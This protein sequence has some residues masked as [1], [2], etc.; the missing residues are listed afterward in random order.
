M[1][2]ELSEEQEELV[3]LLRTVLDQ[4]S[5]GPA[6]RRAMASELGYDPELWRVLSEE[7]GAAALAIPEE[8]GGV[9]FTRLEQSLVLEGLG[10][11]LAPSPYL[12]SV[13]IA[14]EAVRSATDEAVKERLLPGIA[15]GSSIAALAWADPHGRWNPERVDAS[16]DGETRT[17]SGAIPLV[18][19]GAAADVLL[20]VA[21]TPNGPGLFEVRDPAAVQRTVTPALD[22]TLRFATLR[23][24]AVAVDPILTGDA[25]ALDRLRDRALVAVSAL[26][27]GAAERGLAMT[28]EYSKQRVQFGR[29]IGSFQALKHR[30]ADMHVRL[31]TARTASRA[32]SWAS[33]DDDPSLPELAAVAKAWCTDS[34]DL[35]AAETIQLHGGIAITWEHDAQLVFKR[36]QALGALFGTAAEQR[37]RIA[38]SLGLVGA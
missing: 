2:F 33:A 32:A 9:G 29:P 11:N 23:F 24:D 28:V 31:E 26:Q 18:L 27:L 30:M 38:T 3:S 34:L 12:G 16:Y 36:A 4:R 25:A 5:D 8:Y 1:R 19:E 13:A 20:L 10:A 21:Q 15:E 14:A 17:V 6:V 35:I 37:D 7:I 22:P